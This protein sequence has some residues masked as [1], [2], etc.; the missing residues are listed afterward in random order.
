MKEA[1]R[2]SH[3]DAA[4]ESDRAQAAYFLREMQ[5]Q[6]ALLEEDVAKSREQ[7]AQ[8][9]SRNQGFQAE[10]VQRELRQAAVQRREILDMLAALIS[11]FK[12]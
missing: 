12:P 10:R 6:M 3:T 5:R 8:Y 7:L 11:R 1:A 2:R 9:L 4:T